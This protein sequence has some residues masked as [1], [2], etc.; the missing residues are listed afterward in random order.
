MSSSLISVQDGVGQ[1]S[2]IASPLDSQSQLALMLTAGTG[3]TPGDD[4]SPVRDE[5]FQN[6][7]ILIIDYDCCIRAETANFPFGLSSLPRLFL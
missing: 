5:V 3:N 7:N 6:R 2:D 4:F 1:Q